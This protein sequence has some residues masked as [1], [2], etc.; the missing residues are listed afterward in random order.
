MV[1]LLVAGMLTT[2]GYAWIDPESV[3]GMWLFD[4]GDDDTAEDSSGNENDGTLEGA[5]W[6][7]SMSGTTLDFN[8]MSD[9]VDVG[10]DP[11]KGLSG[12][13]ILSISAWVKRV[14][15]TSTVLVDKED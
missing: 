5:M 4:E 9:Y 15:D 11:I 3:I 12:T 6:V 1:A 10:D 8:G 14:A 7:D 13:T 2:Q